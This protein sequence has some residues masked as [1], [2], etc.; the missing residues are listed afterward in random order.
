M[1]ILN[2]EAQT[3]TQMMARLEEFA[4]CIEQICKENE[5]KK[6]GEWLDNCDIKVLFG[7]KARTLQTYRDK[8]LIGYSKIGSK[9]YYR[10]E[11]VVKFLNAA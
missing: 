2:L 1:Q 6:M 9:I 4:Q 5:D 11:D 3:F 7:I 10:A 8:G